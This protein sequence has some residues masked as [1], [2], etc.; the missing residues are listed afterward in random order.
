MAG[1]CDGRAATIGRTLSVSMSLSR[2]ERALRPERG[3][4]QT[5]QASLFSRTSQPWLWKSECTEWRARRSEAPV[6]KRR[7]LISLACVVSVGHV[8]SHGHVNSHDHVTL[9]I[10]SRQAGLHSPADGTKLGANPSPEGN[11]L[12][13]LLA[14]ARQVRVLGF[15]GLATHN[16][17]GAVL[18]LASNHPSL[19]C[20]RSGSPTL[21]PAT[22][23]ST[24]QLR[25]FR[26]VE[27]RSTITAENIV[28]FRG[29]I[30]LG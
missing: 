17:A 19:G 5:V 25:Q 4:P 29:R 22:G 10:A 7:S 18:P 14:K 16:C 1:L 30:K 3:P 23:R 13:P 27:N 21:G 12:Q 24:A 8:K 9:T 2:R 20:S 6:A 15:T 28:Q 11:R 26:S